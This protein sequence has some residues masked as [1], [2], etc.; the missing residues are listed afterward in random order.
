MNDK[1]VAEAA[2]ELSGAIKEN[3][4]TNPHLSIDPD[5]EKTTVLG[6]PAEIDVPK[7]T[8]TLTFAYEEDQLTAEDKARMKFN[9]DTRCYEVE[10]TYTGK[11]IRPLYRGKIVIILTQLLSEIGVIKFEGYTDEV[12]SYTLAGVFYDHTDDIVELA[13]MVLDLPKDQLGYVT[14]KALGSFF[15]QLIKNEPNIIKE[16]NN[17]LS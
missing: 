1:E 10:M 12:A 4:T 8:Y 9:P 5:T 2:A 13:R 6:D 16:C 3:S 17:F 14:P 15:V 11:R 7:G